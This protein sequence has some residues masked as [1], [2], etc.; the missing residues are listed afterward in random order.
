MIWQGAGNIAA[1][2]FIFPKE[3]A[4]PCPEKSVIYLS[5]FS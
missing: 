4:G 2:L 5:L 1:R 3:R